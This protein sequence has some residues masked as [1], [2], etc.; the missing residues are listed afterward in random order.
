M[1]HFISSIF[2]H[3]K[4]N[5]DNKN[6]TSSYISYNI[7]LKNNQYKECVICLDEIKN[8]DKVILTN[9]FHLYH[10]D[11]IQLWFDKHK[12]CPICNNDLKY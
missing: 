4:K 3:F 8:K 6:N 9:C 11:C 2:N 12:L 5:K 1:N 10:E 7:K